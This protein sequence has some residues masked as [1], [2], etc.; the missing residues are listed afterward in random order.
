MTDRDFSTALTEFA[1]A[2]GAEWVFKSDERIGD[3]S[4][5]LGPRRCAESI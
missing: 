4:A 2:I 3:L 5:P 1:N